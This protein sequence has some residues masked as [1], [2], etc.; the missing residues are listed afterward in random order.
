MCTIFQESIKRSTLQKHRKIEREQKMR[1]P[2]VGSNSHGWRREVLMMMRS[3]TS[4]QHEEDP[5][6]RTGQSL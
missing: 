3:L 2:G 4:G 1:D 6:D 5:P